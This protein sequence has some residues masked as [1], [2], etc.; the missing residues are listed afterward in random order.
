MT[1]KKIADLA[2]RK[3]LNELAEMVCKKL[4]LE[5]ELMNLKKSSEAQVASLKYCQLNVE[6]ATIAF[7][8]NDFKNAKHVNWDVDKAIVDY[9]ELCQMLGMLNM[10]EE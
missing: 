6:I 10:I 1:G 2:A 8:M 7:L 5:E 3:A 4:A 9:T